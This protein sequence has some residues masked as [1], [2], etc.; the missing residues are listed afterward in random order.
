MVEM[1]SNYRSLSSLLGLSAA[2]C[3]AQD[4][5]ITNARI[6]VGNGPVIASGTILV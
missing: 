1:K 6:I 3:F 2:A 5:A 4:V